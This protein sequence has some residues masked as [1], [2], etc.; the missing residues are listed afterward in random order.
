MPRLS[1]KVKFF[2]YCSET[3]QAEGAQKNERFCL[4]YTFG[5]LRS[6][7]SADL[8]GQDPRPGGFLRKALGTK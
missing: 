4:D 8:A 2:G 5:V 1:W 3:F 6:L 7:S